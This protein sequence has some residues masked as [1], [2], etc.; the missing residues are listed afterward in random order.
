LQEQQHQLIEIE[1]LQ[2]LTGYDVTGETII[3]VQQ[4]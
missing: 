2:H 1:K 3:E 4:L